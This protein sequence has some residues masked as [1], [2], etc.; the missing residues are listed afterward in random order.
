M[1]L[2]TESISLIDHFSLLED[3]RITK[4]NDHKL[5]SIIMIS[6]CATL[7]GA[8]TWVEMEEFGKAKQS[9]FETFLDLSNGIPSHDTFGRVFSL[10]SHKNFQECFLSWIKSISGEI[11]GVVAIDGKTLRRSHDHSSGKAAIHMVSAWSSENNIV[12]GQIKTEEKSN[13][14]TAI[15]KLLKALD[16]HGCIVTIDAMGCQT[17]ITSQ[18]IDQGGDYVVALKGNQEKLATEVEQLF[19]QA[20]EKEYE[21][22]EWDYYE[23]QNKSHGREEIRRYWTIDC[24]NLL[25]NSGKWSKLN[26]IGMVESTRITKDKTTIEHRYYIA[27]IENDATLFGKSAREHWGVENGLHWCLDIGFREDEC[28]IR[29]GQAAENH[30]LLNHIALNALKREKTSKVGIQAKRH[31]AGWDEE[32]L[33]KV[34]AGI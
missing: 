23:T 9:W 10:L 8:N 30:A 14:I 1:V 3:P 34:L 19:T 12:L 18:V 15:P 16:V 31:K 26:T 22:Y 13:E 29:K 7:C 25:E 33:L 28:R 2:K 24:Q 20:D 21:G 11:K 32:Y 27:S 6:I 4:K 17:A 5:I